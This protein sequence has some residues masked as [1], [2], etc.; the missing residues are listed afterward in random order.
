MIDTNQSVE[1]LQKQVYDLQQDLIHLQR[2]GLPLY[3]S[4]GASLDLWQRSLERI[5]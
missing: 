5:H 3:P 4:Q 1:A 2:S